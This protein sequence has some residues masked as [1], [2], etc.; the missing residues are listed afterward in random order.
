MLVSREKLDSKLFV[1]VVRQKHSD[2]VHAI[3][4]CCKAIVDGLKPLWHHL[5]LIGKPCCEAR[6]DIDP[7]WVEVDCC[8][9][10][11]GNFELGSSV[12]MGFRHPTA[13]EQSQ[14]HRSQR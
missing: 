6:D 2:D 14:P 8:R 5:T 7:R 12:E 3:G 4:R 9:D 13:P 11:H 10:L 1:Y